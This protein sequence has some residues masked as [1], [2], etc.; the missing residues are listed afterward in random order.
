MNTTNFHYTPHMTAVP[1]RL[2][3]AEDLSPEAKLT[4]AILYA[5]DDG[6]QSYHALA[7]A[8]NIPPEKIA[9]AIA[10]LTGNGYLE[11]LEENGGIALH[12]KG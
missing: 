6:N 3:L 12:L 10:E 9:P 4:G 2:L 7:A 11:I 8:L 1:T 5:F